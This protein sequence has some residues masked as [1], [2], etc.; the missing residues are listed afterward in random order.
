MD[1]GAPQMATST[2]TPATDAPAPEV[3]ERHNER[4]RDSA[5][6]LLTPDGTLAP[7]AASPFSDEDLLS[8]YRWMVF[9]RLLDERAVS[10]QRQGRVGTYAAAYGQEASVVG[11]AAAL[12]PATDWIVPQ[13]REAA[14]VV[15]HGY[16]LASLLLY[17][18]GNPLGSQLPEHVRVVPLQISLAAQ[19]PHAVGLG[20][21]R[22][23]QG[24]SDVV[25]TYCGDGASS[26]GDFHEACNWAGVV[27]AP[28]VFLVQNNG[29]AISTPR[30]KQSAAATLASRAEGY[31]I[32]GDLVD[33]ND[34]FAVHGATRR[35]V[36]RARAGAGPTL[37]ECLTYRLYPH[38]TADD[39][40]RY[41]PEGELED[42]RLLDPLVRVRTFL[43]AQGLLT[44]LDD[45]EMRRQISAE[46]AAAVT[47]AEAHPKQTPNQVFDHVYAR[48]PARVVEQQRRATAP[49]EGAV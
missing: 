41:L 24:E 46:I 22:R 35:A 43:T 7:G 23:L 10:L 39:S 30:A 37:I 13:Y 42:R 32:E 28:V 38:N 4:I 31:G 1:E 40:T 20:W 14:A 27:K 47:A 45:E 2:E 18:I 29:Y 36:E 16:P 25:L 12:D 34:L 48:P 3:Y 49:V 21:G 44:A 11:S 6:Q 9:S 33:G 19:L 8:A 5:R 15:R 17:Y 26:E